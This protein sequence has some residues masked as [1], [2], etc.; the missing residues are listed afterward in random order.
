MARI[1]P[2]RAFRYNPGLVRAEDVVTQP[3]DKIS[4]AMQQSYYQ[5]SPYNLVRVIL[6]LPELFDSEENNVY[7]R[8]A[9]NLTEWRKEGVLSQDNEAAIYAYSQRYE[10]P[11]APGTVEERRGFIALGELVD[12]SQGIVFRHERTLAKPKS[13]RLNLLRA[14]RAHFGQIFMLYS[15]PGLTAEQL[16]FASPPTPD[17]EVT[18]EYGVLHRV[19]KVSEP[20]KINLL[21]SAM[22][23]KKLIIADGHH[24]YETALNYSREHASQAADAR[25]ER[26]AGNLP[27]PPYP[28]A[29]AMMTFV[30][31]DAKGLTILPT[32]R[33][34]HGLKDFET[35]KFLK[36]AVEYFDVRSLSHALD[37]PEILCQ[38][39]EAGKTGTSFVAVTRNGNHL[40]TAKKAAIE[41]R[42][43]DQPERQRRLDVVQ[44]HSIVLE[45]VLGISAQAVLDQTNLRYVRE[46]SDAMQQ[47]RA[48]DAEIAFLMNPVTLDQLREVAFAGDVMPQKS[49]DFYPKLLSGLTIYALD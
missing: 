4:P 39:A 33:V 3:Y 44:L 11:G 38:L 14:T 23:N 32:H 45:D 27:Q 21:L 28:A 2:F 5:R 42:L 49:T 41:A 15:D 26:P 17:I 20:G 25:T 30:N 43:T 19:W 48:G 16:L 9:E 31:M 22:Q 37:V 1:Y 12:Y 18:D 24:R 10:V 7:T 36:R 47:V 13:D 6:G 40:L 34:V 35:A 29:A 46:A 8:A